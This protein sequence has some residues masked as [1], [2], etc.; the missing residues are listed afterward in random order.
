MSAYHFGMQQAT[1]LLRAY[2]FFQS[3]NDTE[4]ESAVAW[5][6]TPDIDDF[7]YEPTEQDWMDIRSCQDA[8]ELVPSEEELHTISQFDWDLVHRA[9]FDY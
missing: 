9:P 7:R 1:D 3:V 5:P 4:Y 8:D 2:L 6:R